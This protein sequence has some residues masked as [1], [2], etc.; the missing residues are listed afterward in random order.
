MKELE[1]IFNKHATENMIVWDF[2][3]FK[4]TQPR[5]FLSIMDA[6]AEVRTKY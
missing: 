2:K 3:K 4:S 6:M 5:L 1:E